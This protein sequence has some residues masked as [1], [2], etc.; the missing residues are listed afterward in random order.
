MFV[1][2]LPGPDRIRQVAEE[3]TQ[4]PEYQLENPA[5]SRAQWELL[6]RFLN[7]LLT[8]FRWLFDALEG[9]PTPLRWL[10]VVGLAVLLLVLV[11]HIVYTFAS[12]L[13][14]PKRDIAISLDSGS[15]AERPVFLERRAAEALE[16]A[17]YRDAARFLLCAG[18]M[19][20]EQ[21]HDRPFRVGLTNREYLRRFRESACSEPLAVMV[22]TVD[23]TWYGEEDCTRT[24]FESCRAAY[25]QIVQMT[26]ARAHA[27]S[28]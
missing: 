24:A 23:T 20:L 9:L 4:R 8:P 26:R 2:A 16:R 25:D 3:V 1:Q 17:D 6:L 5:D 28:A 15:E 13:R 22:E 27:D 14:A 7:W 19:R 18:L 10:V 12:A 21:Q 11:A